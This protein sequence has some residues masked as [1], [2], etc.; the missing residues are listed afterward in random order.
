LIRENELIKAIRRFEDKAVI[1]VFK[2]INGISFIITAYASSD[3]GR[4]LG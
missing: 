3:L 2:E 1:V 4:Y